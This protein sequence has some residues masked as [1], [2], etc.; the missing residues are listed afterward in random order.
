MLFIFVSI[1][2]RNAG[3]TVQLIVTDLQKRRHL[4]LVGEWQYG[5]IT[6]KGH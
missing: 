3:R 1:I 4:A 5:H 6:V 2:Q